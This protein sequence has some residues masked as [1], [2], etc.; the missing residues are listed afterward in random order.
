MALDLNNL[1]SGMPGITPS[2]AKS[3]HE[4]AA[5]CLTHNSHAP[6]IQ[7]HVKGDINASDALNWTPPS[8]QALAAWNDLQEATED[9]AY[10][11]AA[12]LIKELTPLTIVQRSR[13]GTGFDYWL[14]PKA[15]SS[16][17]FQDKS[18]LEVSG[19]LT[20][21]GNAVTQRVAIKVNQ[22]LGVPSTLKAWVVV[23]DFGT[24]LGH[25]KLT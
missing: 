1:D 5:T 6:G 23:V 24:P 13:K 21:S 10:G 22:V 19:I 14:G 18:R 25:M 4:A 8:T 3:M 11:I 2:R 16:P 9:G 20:A 15:N 17:M 12:L 7:I